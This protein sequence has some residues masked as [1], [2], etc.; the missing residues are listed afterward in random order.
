MFI[1]NIIDWKNKQHLFQ[2][3]GEVLTSEVDVGVERWANHQSAMGGLTKE[4]IISKEESFFLS[5]GLVDF[6]LLSLGHFLGA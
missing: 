6:S 3:S 4:T 2:N 5:Q 1:A